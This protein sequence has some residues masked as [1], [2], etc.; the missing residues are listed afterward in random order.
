MRCVGLSC[1][2]A[3]N[4]ICLFPHFDLAVPILERGSNEVRD[5]VPVAMSRPTV[6]LRHLAPGMGLDR[7][8]A[9]CLVWNLFSKCNALGHEWPSPTFVI[10]RLNWHT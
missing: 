10:P 6:N 1:L 4:V 3:L 9:R 7:C 2:H 5:A 8:M